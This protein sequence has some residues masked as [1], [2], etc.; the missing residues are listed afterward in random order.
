MFQISNVKIQMLKGGQI[1]TKMHSS[2]RV[3]F[4]ATNMP[5][6]WNIIH[7]K[8]KIHSSVW[9][10]KTFLYDI[11]E[12]RYKQN[13]MGYQISRIIKND[14]SNSVKSDTATIYTL[15]L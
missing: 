7:F 14:Q 4:L 12:L 3:M 11:R 10:T 13:N 8:G 15:F 1:K 9:S 2:F 5:E 6:V